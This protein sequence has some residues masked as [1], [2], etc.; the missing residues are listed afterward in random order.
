MPTYPK[1]ESPEEIKRKIK[2]GR[3]KGEMGAYI[4]WYLTHE[5]TSSGNSPIAWSHKLERQ[6][7]TLSDGE[8]HLW[9][10]LEH[11]QKVVDYWEQY[12]LLGVETTMKIAA[13]HGI[14]YPMV[15]RRNDRSIRDPKVLT[16]DFV[17]S[18][19]VNGVVETHPISFKRSKP[20][21]DQKATGSNT[22]EDLTALGKIELE[23][24]FWQSLGHKLRIVTE[25]DI[26]FAIW[27]NIQQ[28]HSKYK[29]DQ[30]DAEIHKIASY[31]TCC[32]TN[33]SQSLNE[34]TTECD[35]QM[36]YPKDSGISLAVAWHL[37]AHHKWTIDLTKLVDPSKPLK[38]ISNSL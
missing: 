16:T 27:Q 1:D 23:R 21:H 30:T 37:I 31:L 29:I 24:L 28:A 15:P 18:V 22:L 17:A 36:G 5:L 35:A 8:Y 3:G 19:L 13:E 34:I 9:W 32:V 7:H 10:I 2:E 14:R 25:L 38:L 33:E 6:V 20:L 4:P 26:P 11:S 12:P